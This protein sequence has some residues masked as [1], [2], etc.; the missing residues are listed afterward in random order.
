MLLPWMVE[1]F[2]VR[3]VYMIRHPCAVVASQLR[4][5][6]WDE[7]EKSFCDHPVLFA[8]YPHI[9]TVFENIQ[10]QDEILA[11]NWAIQNFVPL[12]YLQDFPDAFIATTYEQMHEERMKEVTRLFRELGEELPS[13]AESMLNQPSATT[14]NEATSQHS[15][16]QL[17]KWRRHLSETQINRILSVTHEVGISL[18]M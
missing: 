16:A 13:R 8:E 15:Q 12:I 10:R 2:G 6:N 11:F 1:R 18:Y 4:H 17:A 3:A 7:V 9:S 14:K 5:G